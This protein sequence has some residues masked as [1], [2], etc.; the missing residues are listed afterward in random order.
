MSD[1][2]PVALRRGQAVGS[3]AEARIQQ[4]VAGEGD[5][6]FADELFGISHGGELRAQEKRAAG[7]AA[8]ELGKKAA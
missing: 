8:E 4:W 2:G 3:L 6:P 5:W 1:S 7:P